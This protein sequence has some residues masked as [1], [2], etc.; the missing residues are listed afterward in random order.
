MK[1][2]FSH[3]GLTLLTLSLAA[4]GGGGSGGSS[5]GFSPSYQMQDGSQ[6]PVAVEVNSNV[7]NFTGTLN[8]VNS[9]LATAIEPTDA[10]SESAPSFS[11]RELIGK[12]HQDWRAAAHPMSA[13]VI[14]A[15]VSDTSPCPSSGSMASSFD[16]RNSNGDWDVTEV[17]SVQFTNCTTLDGATVNGKIQDA[18][19]AET[20]TS[21]TDTLTFTNFKISKGVYSSEVVSGSAVWTST[22]SGFPQNNTAYSSNNYRI[23]DLTVKSTAPVNNVNVTRQFTLNEDLTLVQQSPDFSKVTITGSGSIV[24]NNAN[25]NGSVAFNIT[26]PIIKSVSQPL[27]YGG[28]MTVTGSGG[29]GLYISYAVPDTGSATLQLK[30]DGQNVGTPKV[31][32]VSTLLGF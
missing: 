5:T 7:I 29:T 9:A 27:A 8:D 13:Q 16:D 22:E 32:S 4:C 21:T 19:N 18:F 28:A 24:S 11:L 10:P 23:N 14:G 31:V 15:L 6:Q 25:I 30:H 26:T 3:T 17:G 1:L 12:L 2:P 20:T